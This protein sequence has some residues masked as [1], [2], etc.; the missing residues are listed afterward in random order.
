MYQSIEIV[1][2]DARKFDGNPYEVAGQAIAMADGIMQVAERAIEV[3][4]LMARN[5]HM[6]RELA[7]KRSP[8]GDGWPETPEGL[9]WRLV[10]QRAERVRQDLAVLRK[11]ASYD[12]KH[13][14]KVT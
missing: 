10:V 2:V 4:D 1:F 6:E 3:A 9:R 8:A 14:P 13:P 12:P 7:F 5:A 11:A